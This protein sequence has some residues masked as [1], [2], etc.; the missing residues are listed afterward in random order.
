MLEQKK[1]LGELSKDL[2]A[3]Y[4]MFIQQF[5]NLERET[6]MLSDE[7]VINSQMQELLRQVSTEPFLANLLPHLVK[8]VE[9]KCA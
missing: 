4:T 3:F 1:R 9:S 6:M 8:F 2:N 7:L 5:Q